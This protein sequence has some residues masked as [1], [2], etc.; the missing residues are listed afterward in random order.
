MATSEERFGASDDHNGLF[1]RKNTPSRCTFIVD[2]SERYAL[3]EG[4]AFLLM[5]VAVHGSFWSSQ[6]GRRCISGNVTIRCLTHLSTRATTF[7][8]S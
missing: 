2:F 3:L 1:S 8:G 5:V 7:F 6:E 4:L